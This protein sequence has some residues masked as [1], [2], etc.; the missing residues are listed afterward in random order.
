MPRILR[1]F[2]CLWLLTGCSTAT[3]TAIPTTNIPHTVASLSAS[4]TSIPTASLSASG[5]STV[6]AS[7][8]DGDLR[9]ALQQTVD[10]WSKAYAD[11]SADELK[12]AI[13]QTDLSF[14]RMQADQLREESIAAAAGSNDYQ[15]TVSGITPRQYGYVQALVNFKYGQRVFI[16]KQVAGRWMIS[17]PRVEE[18]GKIQKHKTDHFNIRYYLWDV[19]IVDEM[20]RLLEQAYTDD[21]AKLG[22]TPKITTDVFVSPS[23]TIGTGFLSGNYIAQYMGPNHLSVTS[24]QTFEPAG[25]LRRLERTLAHEYA[26]LINDCCFV[27]LRRER[28]WMAEGLAVYISEGGYANGFSGNVRAA[29]Q[30]HRLLPLYDLQAVPGSPGHDLEHMTALHQDIGLAYGEAAA[31]TAYIVDHY[32]GIDGYWKFINDFDKTQDTETSLQHVFGISRARFE[33]GWQAELQ[34]RY[35]TP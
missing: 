27:H 33:Q 24:P 11:G 16:F 22:R 18:L 9:Q 31:L 14:R 25:S 17:E 30:D 6:S 1:F 29:V 35:S 10:Q 21:I 26:H 15:A 5:T 8:D 23:T 3:S 19:G 7:R 20:G 12:A 34:R 32:G 13:D 4:V 2:V 28:A